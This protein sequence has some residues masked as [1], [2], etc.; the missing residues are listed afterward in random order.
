MSEAQASD[1][2]IQLRA[3]LLFERLFEEPAARERLLSR[4]PPA[5]RDAVLTL[6]AAS[7]RSRSSFPTVDGEQPARTLMAI[8]RSVG[9]YRLGELIGEGGMALVFAA[10]RGDGL[11]EHRVAV[12]LIH[13]D[14]FTPSA[15]TRFAE[16]RRILARI[17]HPGVA[18][19]IDGGIAEGWPYIL[20]ERVDGLPITR[21][22]QDHGLS[23]QDR[24]RLIVE[25][26]AAVSAAHGALIAHGDI[27]PDNVLVEQSGRVRLL[28]FG[29]ARLIEGDGAGQSS[30]LTPAF[31]SP[32]RRAGGLP[33]VSDDLYALGLLLA[34]TLGSAPYPADLAAIIARAAAPD[35]T[36][37]YSGADALRADLLRWL[38]RRPVEAR[39]HRPAYVTRLFVARNRRTLAILAMALLLVAGA[40]ALAYR[41]WSEARMRSEQADANA[42]G[43]RRLS[44]YLL[45]D[46]YDRLAAQPGTAQRRAEIAA[47]AAAYLSDLHVSPDADPGLRLETARA[48]RR[49]AAVQGLPSV[50]NLGLPDAARASIASAQ[51]L[52][53]GAGDD[54]R[55]EMLSERGWLAID[56]WALDGEGRASIALTHEAR[57][58]FSA[59]RAIDPR[60][61]ASRLGLIAAAANEAYD[62]IWTLDRPAEARRMLEASLGAVRDHT[63]PAPLARQAA[64]LEMRMLARLGDAEYQAGRVAES[65]DHFVAADR[66]LDAAIALYGTTPQFVIL[67]GEYAFDIAGTLEEFPTRL[68]EAIGV[69]DRGIAA[70]RALLAQGTDA[71]A[72]KKLLVLLAEKAV[73]LRRQGRI[74]AAITPSAASVALREARL[75]G[76]PADP[77]RMRDL[78]IGLAPH[79]ELLGEAG[80]HA[81]ACAAAERAVAMWAR[82]DAAGH[83][84]ALDKR[85]NQPNAKAL[86]GRFC[87]P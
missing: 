22:A 41:G 37:R 62:L 1:A 3:L 57:Q 80:R 32:E 30:P 17:E 56:R 60:D 75:A 48:Y 31:A 58:D 85:K 78:A 83:L 76:T 28:D 9:D 73:L 54:R 79:A 71:A 70:L 11:F 40:G 67:K 33:S 14:C 84:G 66:R 34:A 19:L 24:V 55:A 25:V 43:L 23:P 45:G 21:F 68:E 10:D 6:E 5:V 42:A 15:L 82:I 2:G 59:A 29:V 18:R 46:L 47:Q 74:V 20:M 16:E 26:C 49:L 63:W 86:Q 36:A 38:E 77:Q 81:D 39:R 51:H 35:I 4:E 50:T 27:K 53:A 87:R 61:D 69:A 7:S 65:L 52:L 12:K 64:L 13:P 72:E 8:P 44:R